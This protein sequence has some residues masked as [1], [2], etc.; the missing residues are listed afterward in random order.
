MKL[1][2]PLNTRLGLGTLAATA[3][4]AAVDITGRAGQGRPASPD[5][6]AVQG[7]SVSSLAPASEAVLKPAGASSVASAHEILARFVETN[8]YW[9]LGPPPAVR[10]LSYTLNR[11]GTK[12]EFAVPDPASASRARLQGMTYSTLLHRLALNPA[13][14]DVR[15]FTEEMGRIRLTFAFEP[16]L[17]VACGNG[18]ETGW[19]GYFELTSDTG[20]LVLDARRLVPLEAGLGNLTETFA[21]FVPVD[22]LHNVPLAVTIQKDEMRFDW[23]FRLYEPGL[24]LFDDSQ[25]GDRRVTWVE[26]VKVNEAPAVL[27]Q[28]TAASLARDAAE[29]VGAP[30]LRALLNANQPWL[31]PSLPARRGLIYEYRQEAPYLERVLFDPEGNVMVRLEDS[32]ENPG[33]ATRQMLW[34]KDGRR[35]TGDSGDRYVTLEPASVA[36]EAPAESRAPLQRALQNLAVGLGWDCALTQIA[37]EPGAFWIER[38][39]ANAPGQFLLVAHARKDARLFA[40]TMLTFTSWANMHDVRFD[41]SEILCDEAIQRPLVERD[42]A[43]KDELRGEFFFEGWSNDPSGAVPER[44]R[45]VIPFQQDGKD[46]S[47]EMDARFQIAKPGVWLL[48]QVESHFRGAE[49]GSTGT[50][51]LA[52]SS[53]AA[54]APVTELLARL[55]TT[56]QIFAAIRAAPEGIVELRELSS[57]WKPC[58]LRTSWTEQARKAADAE[59]GRSQAAALIGIHRARL[60]RGPD[61]ATRMSLD[62]VTTAS[63]KEFETEWKVGWYDA[64][65]KLTGSAATN[66]VVRAEGGPAPFNISVAVPSWPG[67]ASAPASISVEGKARRLTASYFGSR[68]RLSLAE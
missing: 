55:S 17:R 62:G 21:E 33:K 6:A 48:S 45:G 20:Y 39:A 7:Q 57:D 64:M 36:A 12:Q 68:W 3:M 65:G 59:R 11:L 32:K 58:V 30:V 10:Q 29:A 40:G 24:W 60:E 2:A 26:D 63:W 31:L 67:Q 49:R 9:L 54:F 51:S 4:I 15:G 8:R 14:A 43:G 25:Y 16:P 22:A 41:R 66:V 5:N 46:Q 50:V 19:T 27:R 18:V 61:G 56:E 42:L 53:A 1:I 13:S 34:L 35:M 38:Q 47:L 28:A 23:R 37:R 44:I 52:T